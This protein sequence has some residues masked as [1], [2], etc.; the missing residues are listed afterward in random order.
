MLPGAVLSCCVAVLY[1]RGEASAHVLLTSIDG[2]LPKVP[3]IQATSSD[4]QLRQE[5][6]C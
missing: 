1:R 5:V 3:N 2:I 4:L 6:V